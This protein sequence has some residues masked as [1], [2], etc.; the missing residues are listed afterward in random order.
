LLSTTADELVEFLKEHKKI[1]IKNLVE[2]LKVSRDSIIKIS[3][4]LEEQK[5]LKIEYGLFGIEI[6]YVGGG[7]YNFDILSRDSVI[8]II[9]DF[10]TKMN[11]EHAKKFMGDFKDYC[12]SKKD[13]KFQ[14]YY[15]EILKLF[16]E[17]FHKNIKHEENLKNPN[18]NQKKDVEQL[19]YYLI[20]NKNIV[21][22][23]IIQKEKNKSIP[24]YKLNRLELNYYTETI[25]KKMKDGI[26]SRLN[27]DK[28]FNITSGQT[29]L[30]RDE[31]KNQVM[32]ELNKT[33]ENLSKEDR[34]TL[35]NFIF[36]TGLG[37]G[38]I[39]FLLKD[40]NL[41][42]IVINNA[43]DSIWVYHRKYGWLETNI[44]IGDETKIRHFAT[45]G[46]RVVDKN[47]TNL[48]PLLDGHLESGDRFNATLAPITSKGNTITIRKFAQKPWT[49]TD[50]LIKGAISYECAAIIW[51]SIQFEMSMLIVG[52]TGSGKTSA[53]NVYSSFIP[54]NQRIISIEDTRELTLA[55]NLHWIP[56]QTR[57][58]NPEG[59]GCISMLDLIINSLRMRPD[60]ILFGE[61]RKK[62]EAE[63][64]FE[65]MHTG[66]SAV[67]TF[68]ANTAEESFQRLTGRPIEL[69]PIML[70]SLSLIVVQNRNRRTGQRVVLQLSEVEPSGHFRIIYEYNY[71]TNKWVKVND[72]K[73]YYKNLEMF[74]GLT[75]DEVV[76][77]IEEKKKILERFAKANINDVDEIG[78]LLSKYYINKEYFY[79]FLQEIENAKNGIS[80][81][82]ESV[83]EKMKR[84]AEEKKKKLEE[85]KARIEKEKQ[86]IEQNKGNLNILKDKQEEPIS[87]IEKA[88]DKKSFFKKVFGI[89]NNN[90]SSDNIL[91]ESK[92]LVKEE[93]TKDKIEKEIKKEDNYKEKK[94][95]EKIIEDKNKDNN[96]IIINK[97]D[98]KDKQNV[99]SSKKDS[100][101]D[102]NK[103]INLSNN[104]DKIIN[105][106]KINEKEVVDP[107]EQEL[108][109]L[110]KKDNIQKS[111]LNI[112]DSDKKKVD[113]NL[114]KLNNKL[115][116]IDD[117]LKELEEKMGELD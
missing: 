38:D 62:E 57:P 103:K 33:F 99:N 97:K 39:E 22:D 66:H 36:I 4:Y 84:S 64:L 93:K 89:F 108:V 82:G 24:T 104:E 8:N 31:F 26:I 5:I 80:G 90:I 115:K 11:Y 1:S 3:Q 83:F 35:C 25:L 96:S 10:K 6:I 92:K 107:I 27:Y 70:S 13:K 110:T 74:A 56:M 18:E 2:K 21:M 77:E 53:L 79:K 52:G 43:Q 68:H 112:F 116:S 94:I 85:E 73:Y 95:E 23:V 28:V 75:K 42:E 59:K 46:G 48:E 58:P 55:S 32:I 29:E 113:K 109:N 9:S 51:L 20:W 15:E 98:S 37:L 86:I 101:S 17:K 16:K 69:D 60:R 91:E 50:L 40:E 12:S 14:D 117:E 44:N 81:A 114:E 76:K 88:S 19:E 72:F 87:Y 49:I 30:I 61:I 100:S 63:V 47:I 7:S 102:I 54:S 78:N 41:E 71:G 106:L 45:I 111:Y 105:N 67:A 65:A 34:T